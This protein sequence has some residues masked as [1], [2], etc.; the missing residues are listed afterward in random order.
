MCAWLLVRLSIAVDAQCGCVR[1]VR[2]QKSGCAGEVQTSH[3]VQ[4]PR[5]AAD[6]LLHVGNVS[7]IDAYTQLLQVGQMGH[8]AQ[9]SGV[10]DCSPV[11]CVLHPGRKAQDENF[12]MR[13]EVWT[14]QDVEHTARIE[15]MRP[16]TFAERLVYDAKASEQDLDEEVA[17]GA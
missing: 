17:E 16:L 2:G 6:G 11:P 3:I 10:V 9:H 14:R 8:H 15:G 4:V 7:G 12:C 1:A 5:A 13:G